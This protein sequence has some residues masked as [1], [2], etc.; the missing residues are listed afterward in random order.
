MKQAKE[1]LNLDTVTKIEKTQDY[2][3][4][5]GHLGNLILAQKSN[6]S[7]SR[8]AHLSEKTTC[9][10]TKKIFMIEYRDLSNQRNESVSE[11]RNKNELKLINQ[12]I[13]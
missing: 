10:C 1:N 4:C 8:N 5:I 9:V 13:W 3:M 11:S 7:F 6:L 2:L 12:K